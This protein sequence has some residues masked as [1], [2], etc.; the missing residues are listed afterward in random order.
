MV[1]GHGKGKKKSKFKN[2]CY[3]CHHNADKKRLVWKQGRH[4]TNKSIKVNDNGT[5]KM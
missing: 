2:P 5:R 3:N 4:K 1:K